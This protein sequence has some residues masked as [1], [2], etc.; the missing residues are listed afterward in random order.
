MMKWDSIGRRV[1]LIAA[2]VLGVAGGFVAG[3]ALAQQTAL[4]RVEEAF[5][6][7]DADALLDEAADRVEIALLGGSKLY[8]RAQ[9]TYVMKDFF[10]RYPPEAFTPRNNTPDGSNW[11]ATGLYRYKHTRQPLQVYLRLHLKDQQWQLREVR[12]EQRQGE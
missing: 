11:F 1:W 6:N 5:K 3:P 2:L 12:I 7:G 9:A 10:Q 8:S 4:D